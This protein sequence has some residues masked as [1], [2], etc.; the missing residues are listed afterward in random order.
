VNRWDVV[1]IMIGHNDAKKAF[2]PD[3]CSDDSTMLTCPVATDMQAML[4]LVKTRGPSEGTAPKIAL[5]LEAN[6]TCCKEGARTCSDSGSGCGYCVTCSGSYQEK[7]TGGITKGVDS[8]V[9]MVKLPALMKAVAAADSSIT[10]LTSAAD[11]NPEKEVASCERGTLGATTS[12]S[13][14]DP[15]NP[16]ACAE[17]SAAVEA[18]TLASTCMGC[19]S[20]HGGHSLAGKVAKQV[21]SDLAT[22]NIV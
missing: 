5:L 12:A 18:G 9:R 20:C 19:R 14:W 15:D 7:Y 2:W 3:S 6:P 1:L 8:N 4:K 22:N 17:V 10:Y 13:E 16:K 21:A 11:A